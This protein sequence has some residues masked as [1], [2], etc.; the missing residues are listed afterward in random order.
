MEFDLSSGGDLRSRISL[1]LLT[2]FIKKLWKMD[3]G[4]FK[5]IFDELFHFVIPTLLSIIIKESLLVLCIQTTSLSKF[6]GTL[7]S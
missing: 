4:V 7:R 6:A 1:L 5:T 2:F 3:G